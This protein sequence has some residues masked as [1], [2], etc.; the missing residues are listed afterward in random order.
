MQCILERN[1]KWT[2]VYK[3]FL[4]KVNFVSLFKCLYIYKNSGSFYGKK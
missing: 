4:D 3:Y 2:H 1:I